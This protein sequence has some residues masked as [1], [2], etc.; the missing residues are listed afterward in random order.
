MLAQTALEGFTE[1]NRTRLYNLENVDRLNIG[2][3]PFLST[4][5][6]F[7]KLR[8][9]LMC[10]G[11]GP[12][13]LSAEIAQLV[14][15]SGEKRTGNVGISAYVGK[16][17]P[18]NLMNLPT[19][20]V[21]KGIQRQ[22][23]D[24]TASS[25]FRLEGSLD[26]I[27]LTFQEKKVLPIFLYPTPPWIERTTSTGKPMTSFFLPEAGDNLM[28]AIRVNGGCEYFLEKQQCRFCGLDFIKG[29]DKKTPEEYAEVAVAAFEERPLTSSLTLTAGN[30]YTSL[31]GIENYLPVISAI[32]QTI[33]R[34]RLISNHPSIEI[35]ASPPQMDDPESIKVLDALLE[36]GVTSMMSNLEQ[37]SPIARQVALPGKSQIPISDYVR[38]FA[39]LKERGIPAS[40]VLMV[41]L[42]DSDEEIIKGAQFLA[43]NGVYPVILPFR[44]RGA[45]ANRLPTDPNRLY[46][47][48]MEVAKIA[49][50]YG[51]F[52]N[53][54][55]CAQCG[56]C[57]IDIQATQLVK[58]IQARKPTYELDGAR[59]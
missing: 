23:T 22:D 25:P 10:M 33:N 24:F 6:N 50:Q 15:P 7:L 14:N 18:P 38:F 57:S 51:V 58:S 46:V 31:R 47:V 9:A 45:Y 30:T 49:V 59:L 12:S 34:S 44:P 53:K 5:L 41:G 35:E 13:D 17:R 8:A 27:V 36:A 4:Q 19:S 11:I 20:V 40:S 55:G 3:F 43:Q 39:Y 1:E 28:G 42:E 2:S 21:Y 56:G 52:P 32:T 16:I 26:E 29:G 54:P 37:F 48:S